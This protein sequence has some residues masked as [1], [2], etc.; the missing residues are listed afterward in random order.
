[1]KGRKIKPIVLWQKILSLSL[2]LVLISIT[3]IQASHDHPNSISV[4]PG[5]DH[6]FVSA[7]EKC[8]ICGYLANHQGKKAYLSHSSALAPLAKPVTLVF[9]AYA[10]TYKFTLQGFINKGPPAAVSQAA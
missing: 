6:S 2:T 9:I 10:G 8:A 1:M 7:I 4:H 5:G 3:A